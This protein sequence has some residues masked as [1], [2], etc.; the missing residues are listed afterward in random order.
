[1]L[2][3]HAQTVTLGNGNYGYGDAALTLP[4][5][6]PPLR[7]K[8]DSANQVCLVWRDAS[9]PVYIDKGII[10]ASC[11]YN[12]QVHV[13]VELFGGYFPSTSHGQLVLGEAGNAGYN[14]APYNITMDLEIV[15]PPVA[16][17]VQHEGERSNGPSFVGSCRL[18]SIYRDT[19]VDATLHLATMVT[20]KYSDVCL[21]FPRSGRRLWADQSILAK[22]SPYFPALFESEFSEAAELT[23]I[24]Q[25]ISEEEEDVHDSREDPYEF[26]DSDTEIDAATRIASEED[27]VSAV[28]CYKTITI[29]QHTYETYLSLLCWIGTGNRLCLRRA[30]E[31]LAQ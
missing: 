27:K 18:F 10:K 21:Y 7:I 20:Q 12:T 14:A 11:G 23:T 4:D 8:I 19:P 6:L 31:E 5:P 1:M 24:T 2:V 13:H 26:D 22:V 16:R 25:D 29:T 17:S 15:A 9:D 30:C 28:P 3:Q